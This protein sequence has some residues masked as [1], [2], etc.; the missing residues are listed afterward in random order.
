MKITMRNLSFTELQLHIISVKI[1]QCVKITMR[2]LSFTELQLHIISVSDLHRSL[3][4]KTITSNFL[5]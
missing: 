3:I 1:Q 4:L 5:M 2:N